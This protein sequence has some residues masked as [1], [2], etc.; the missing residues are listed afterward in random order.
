MIVNYLQETRE[1]YTQLRDE[2]SL[3]AQD[4]MHDVAVIRKIQGYGTLQESS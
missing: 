4:T 2:L 3:Y 1:G